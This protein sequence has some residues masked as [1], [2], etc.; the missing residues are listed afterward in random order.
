MADPIPTLLQ[1]NPTTPTQQTAAPQSGPTVYKPRGGAATYDASA[2]GI[3]QFKYP[4]DLMSAT[5]QYGGNYVIFY[6]NV[7]SDSKLIKNNPTLV[8]ND[9]TPRDQGSL[10][11][12]AQASSAST[13]GV[14]GAAALPAAAGV[15]TAIGT[16]NYGAAALTGTLAVGGGAAVASQAASFTGQTKRIKTTIAMHIPNN[17]STTYGIEYNPEDT[18][19]YA[20]G[21]LGADAI[22][23]ATAAFNKATGEK[24]LSNVA[25]V[26]KQYT[27]AVSSA[28][29]A[30]ALSAPGMAGL[31]KLTGLAANPR[32]EQIFQ[33]VSFREFSFDYQ[34]FPRS[35]EEAQNVLDIIYQ[36]KYHMHP[37]FKDSSQFLYV[38]PSEFDIFYYNNDQENMN[39]N[40]HTSCVLTDMT[41]NYAPQ[42]QFNTFD[43][44]MPTQIDLSLKFKELATLTKEKIADGL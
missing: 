26:A 18:A 5:N 23:N 39:L 2:Y 4:S 36:F 30:G 11:G 43:N 35:E 14:L 32:K 3:D 25:D 28:I 33:G 16:G 27:P 22:A 34:F 37:E 6:I 1:S 24:G 15:A 13:A 7:A 42:G 17:L 9:N 40:R 41:V 31:S 21:L 20:A 8:V 12:L 38:Y 19:L 44:G 10:V 29:A